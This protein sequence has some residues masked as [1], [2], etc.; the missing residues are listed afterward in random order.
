MI[1]SEQHWLWRAVDADGNVLDILLQRHRDKAAAKKLLLKL[2]KQQG[3]VPRVLVTD[4]LKSYSPAKREL[5]PSIEHRQ[6]KGLNNRAEASHQPTR[7]TERRMQR[8][9]SS[10]QAQR[11]LSAFEMYSTALSLQATSINCSRVSPG[12]ARTL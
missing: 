6:H 4:K 2:L 9:K 5:L 1:N 11:F 3:F 10:G 12:D 7:F 8:F